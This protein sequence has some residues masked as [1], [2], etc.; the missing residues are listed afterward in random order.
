MI[1]A[2]QFYRPLSERWPIP[3]G[4]PLPGSVSVDAAA[5]MPLAVP[6]PWGGAEIGVV[7]GAGLYALASAAETEP[8]ERWRWSA[9]HAS[10][11]THVYW[12]PFEAAVVWIDRAPPRRAP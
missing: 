12:R 5:A 10:E 4:V 8:P 3:A 11:T 1:W 6:I 7:Y 2:V 9:T